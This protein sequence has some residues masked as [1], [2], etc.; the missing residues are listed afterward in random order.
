MAAAASVDPL[1]FWRTRSQGGAQASE[2][3]LAQCWYGVV[4]APVAVPSASPSS[5][6]RGA[7]GGAR[8]TSSRCEFD[9]LQGEIMT[10]LAA[11]RRNSRFRLQPGQL[12]SE[13][14]LVSG[15]KQLAAEI[16]RMPAAAPI[17]TTKVDAASA[18]KP[19]LRIIESEEASGPTTSAALHAVE[20][21]LA[22]GFVH[23]AMRRAARAMD[24]VCHAAMHCR[25]EQTDAESDEVI[26]TRIVTLLRTC[27]CSAAGELVCDERIEA[28][29]KYIFAMA[30]E[31]RRSQLLRNQAELVV[32]EVV[33]R[34]FVR[35]RT[36]DASAAL[37]VE[38]DEFVVL[39]HESGVR[40]PHGLQA[41]EAVLRFL[42]PLVSFESADAAEVAMGFELLNTA[43]GAA[44]AAMVQFP[45]LMQEVKQGVS[46][47]L[48][49]RSADKDLTVYA[50]VVRLAVTVLKALRGG[51]RLQTQTLLRKIFLPVLRGK[52][53]G[54]QL[55]HQE[56]AMHGL[57]ELCSEPTFAVELY[58][59]FDCELASPDLL[60]ELC[61]ELAST[62][63]PMEGGEMQIRNSLALEVL[64]TLFFRMAEGCEVAATGIGSASAADVAALCRTQYQDK[65]ELMVGVE[66]FNDRPKKGLQMFADKG[67][68]PASLEAKA[69]ADFLRRTPTLRK[70]KLG[71]LFGEP[72][73]CYLA[74]LREWLDAFDFASLEFDAAIR[75]FLESFRLPGE[76]QKIDRIMEAFAK[77]Y[78]T[79]RRSCFADE[80]AAFVLA[81]SLIMLN[82]NQHS[83]QLK[84]R[85]RMTLAQFLSNNRQINGGE[86]F[87]E[88]FMRPLYD[89]ITNNEIKMS[90]DVDG[91]GIT[92]DIWDDLLRKSR[93]EGPMRKVEIDE[94]SVFCYDVCNLA[95][96][97]CEDELLDN[98]SR[99]PAGVYM[100]Q[101]VQ[102]IRSTALCAYVQGQNSQ[103]D[104]IIERLCS[105]TPLLQQEPSEDL[106]SS[107]AK[108]RQLQMVVN[109]LFYIARE[110]GERLLSGW[111]LVLRCLVACERSELLPDGFLAQDALRYGSP[112]WLAS[113][114]ADDTDAD[115]LDVAQPL[116]IDVSPPA[117][118]WKSMSETVLAYT[119]LAARAAVALGSPEVR[120]VALQ[121]IAEARPQELILRSTKLSDKGLLVLV[122]SMVGE[123]RAAVTTEGPSATPVLVR[124]SSAG[125]ITAAT[126][127]VE[128]LERLSQ[129]D[130]AFYV[131]VLAEIAQRN[132]KRIVCLWPT[133]SQH[134]L[135]VIL[136]LAPPDSRIA[137]YSLSAYLRVG[138][139][140]LSED[141]SVKESLWALFEGLASL[142]DE[143]LEPL[144]SI[145]AVELHEIVR[146]GFAEIAVGQ[147][148]SSDDAPQVWRCIFNLMERTAALPAESIDVSEQRS[149]AHAFAALR[150]V[151][152][153]VQHAV[154][155]DVINSSS[156]SDCVSAVLAFAE[157]S[158][159]GSS[160]LAGRATDA[161]GAM[162]STTS[163]D[164][165]TVGHSRSIQALD[166]LFML[167]TV[168]AGRSADNGAAGGLSL[169]SSLLHGLSV[170]SRDVR[171]EVRSHALSLLQTALGHSSVLGEHVDLF[172]PLVDDHLAQAEAA[173]EVGHT[174][175]HAGWVR[176]LAR[177]MFVVSKTFVT[178]LPALAK[179]HGDLASET[180]FELLWLQLLDLLEK[181]H[182]GCSSDATRQA[183]VLQSLR[184]MVDAAESA[185]VIAPADAEPGSQ[186]HSAAAA[187]LQITTTKIL[188]RFLGVQLDGDEDQTDQ[189]VDM[190]SRRQYVT[191][192]EPEP[193]PEPAPE[194]APELE[195]APKRMLMPLGVAW[196]RAA[197]DDMARR[198]GSTGTPERTM[199]MVLPRAE[200]GF[201]MAIGHAPGQGQGNV[202]VCVL[203]INSETSPAAVAGVQEGWLVVEVAGTPVG[204]KAEVVAALQAADPAT[205][206]EFLFS[207]KRS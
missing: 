126:S 59:N 17:R 90:D 12:H 29:I 20:R 64:S 95:W 151:V 106:V 168:E 2:P 92:S 102:C 84:D 6:L 180:G 18:L 157:P 189:E 81:F 128:K 62:A 119:G 3:Q 55:E 152:L 42:V 205:G 112:E 150:F 16:I 191:E 26:Y 7:D 125:G 147:G 93:L 170:M 145:L 98:F 160:T 142:P 162:M 69:V 118:L 185:G 38:T 107:L 67:I 204:S 181:G 129:D 198:T 4:G 202:C 60:Q 136:T 135:D 58:V 87:P 91:S 148:T 44:G 164:V 34:C 30:H 53:F 203:G 149:A 47:A 175:I 130:A 199:R 13:S 120:P 132:E 11:L 57:Y 89:S 83:P 124:S 27:L 110:F 121:C 127:G 111:P 183:E 114:T 56:V 123:V 1:L 141:S 35:L 104:T 46:L 73:D 182:G 28:T 184:N 80:D 39:T 40:Q 192:P 103:L 165:S 41:A 61:A 49:Q 99:L 21:L 48:I 14:P 23:P 116:A 158:E 79:Q 86:N 96:Q 200:E 45:A 19:F 159:V 8:Q 9:A 68:V 78:F 139:R 133:V 178:L 65:K 97:S 122:S 109:E 187:Q 105:M 117:G 76:A 194:P 52:Q 66:L 193:E 70:D 161:A 43:I 179:Q 33:R 155:E 74:I 188:Q 177:V 195:P 5:P 197:S 115:E 166:L 143:R 15:L 190:A 113:D 131:D 85:E 206:V 138:A 94:C 174:D 77:R 144:L 50:R 173:A 88:E 196:A 163:N 82:T 167:G 25:F 22:Q 101:T 32:L 172:R 154:H 36:V 134:L 37:G 54:D 63:A 176:S 137:K 140:L 156:F 72:E 146:L 207:E 51:L 24:S 75:V 201:G 186:N 108:S 100:E 171:E 169:D 10:M 31:A 153:E 71:E